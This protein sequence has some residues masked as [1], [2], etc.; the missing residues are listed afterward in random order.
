MQAGKRR[1]IAKTQ[2]KKKLSELT[3]DEKAQLID[4]VHNGGLNVKEAAKA[5]KIHLSAAKAVLTAAEKEIKVGE[6]NESI[7]DQLC[8]SVSLDIVQPVVVQGETCE[9]CEQTSLHIHNIYKHY[10]YYQVGDRYKRQ[11]IEFLL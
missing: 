3:P 5:T 9:H 6:Q 4:L 10:R 1:A 2:P 7:D 11:K 8:F